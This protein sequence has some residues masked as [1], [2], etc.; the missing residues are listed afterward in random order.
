MAT[1]PAAT[2][3]PSSTPPDC[4]ALAHAKKALTAAQ[5]AASTAQ[6]KDSNAQ[7]KLTWDEAHHAPPPVIA[8][9]ET[10]LGTAQSNMII[11]KNELYTA[12]GN[13]ERAKEAAQRDRVQCPDGSTTTKPT[14]PPPPPPT[15][16]ANGGAGT[17]A[18]SNSSATSD[19]SVVV[20]GGNATGG[21]AQANPVVDPTVVLDPTAGDGSQAT[22]SG[23][24]VT[25]V[26]TGSASTG[27]A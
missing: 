20:N 7:S 23:S 24:E 4:I 1:A 21:S 15:G 25:D 13:V 17:S 19:D 10:A 16:S 12:Q 9:D 18:S 27:A 6:N 8:A 5:E 3:A 11:A 22:T 2:A 14:T 26:P